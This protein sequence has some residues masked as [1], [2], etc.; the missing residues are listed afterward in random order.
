MKLFDAA[1]SV[2]INQIYEAYAGS[3]P[4]QY[5]NA[6]CPFQGHDD[7]TAS[8]HLYPDTNTFYCFGCKKG[9]TPVDFVMFC[10]GYAFAEDAA[11]DIC[12]KF[13]LTYE[14]TPVSPDIQNYYAVYDYCVSAF[15]SCLSKNTAGLE[16]LMTSRCLS[17]S[18]I[19]DIGYCPPAFIGPKSNK[20][21]RFKDILHSKFPILPESFLD[22]LGLYNASGQC[23]FSDRYVVPIRDTKGKVI[24]FTARA[25]SPGGVPKYLNT[26]ETTLYKK[27]E[28]LFNMHNASKH[29]T[30]YVVEGA[31]DALSLISAGIDN[32]VAPLGTSL[33]KE[34]LDSLGTRAKTIVL[35]YDND[36]AGIKTMCKLIAEYPEIRFKTFDVRQL[37]AHKDFNDALVAKVDIPSLLRKPY[38]L[39]GDMFYF[40]N[41]MA[42][43]DLSSMED[44]EAFYND[45]SAFIQ[46]R[47]YVI[48]DYIW[49]KTLRVITGKRS[50]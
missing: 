43:Y 24:A 23:V 39:S 11:K 34:H 29:S 6:K 27:R 15:S 48:A 12:E 49:T 17:P 1:N 20:V 13:N 19:K 25:A 50:L 45:M 33:T 38:I 42:A 2:S 3:I 21:Y 5:G 44:R 4:P 26:K 30:I 41:R 31:F 22:S 18:S 16:Y 47:P 10:T 8:L 7:S 28:V 46:K 35:A 14:E 37:G 9:K 40:I 36:S 32:V